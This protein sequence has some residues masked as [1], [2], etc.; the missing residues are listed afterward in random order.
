[1]KMFRKKN[2]LTGFPRLTVTLALGL[3]ICITSLSACVG[4]KSPKQS[5]GEVVTIT[6]GCFSHKVEAYNTLVAEFEQAHPNI[7]VQLVEINEAFESADPSDMIS[8][9]HALAEAADTFVWFNLELDQAARLG[10]LLNLK[11]FM[12]EAGFGADFVPGLL[13]GL[14]WADGLWVLPAYFDLPLLYYRRDP[15]GAAGVPYPDTDW[16]WDDLLSAAR[17]LT[18]HQGGETARYGFADLTGNIFVALVYQRGGELSRPE[19]GLFQPTLDSPEAVDALAWY[20]V[21]ASEYHVMP[22]PGTFDVNQLRAMADGGQIAMWTDYAS[23]LGTGSRQDTSS[24]IGVAPLPK[25]VST[26]HPIL[27]QGYAVSAGTRHP[28]AAWQW[29]EFLSR[30]TTPLRSGTPVPARN[31][32]IEAED[33]WEIVGDEAAQ[34]IRHALNHTLPSTEAWQFQTFVRDLAPVFEGEIAPEDFMTHAQAQALAWQSQ[35]AA[36]KPRPFTV[37]TPVPVAPKEAIV[38]GVTDGFHQGIYQQMAQEFMRQ[39]PDIAI[40]VQNIASG[41]EWV[42]AA[43]MRENADVFLLEVLAP[44]TLDLKPFIE[45]DE[46]FS[47]D[48]VLPEAMSTVRHGGQILGLPLTAD[49]RVIFFNKDLFDQAG[50]PYPLPDWTWDEFLEKAVLL[51]QG[52]GQDRQYGFLSYSPPQDLQL[53]VEG[54]CQIIADIWTR[55]P[56]YYFDS[57]AVKDALRWWVA[58]YREHGVMPPPRF[59]PSGDF[60]Y[61]LLSK[62]R[63]AMWTNWVSQY[64]A[65]WLYGPGDEPRLG[66]VPF[67]RGPCSVAD[68]RFQFGYISPSTEKTQECWTWLKY[69]NQRLPAGHLAPVR[70]SLLTS[71]AFRQQVGEAMADACL[72]ALQADAYL[73]SGRLGAPWINEAMDAIAEG[74]GVDEALDEAQRRAEAW[75]QEQRP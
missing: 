2:R 74:A 3:V 21:L 61:G 39:H 53:Y 49:V 47:L 56:V 10:I 43:I 25:D 33:Y 55:P 69:L 41:R 23:M 16:R 6:F 72:H 62:R 58:L 45:A 67:P 28:Q 20:V 7:N 11:P 48:D 36:E 44:R 51:T 30:R 59:G 60:S 38:F 63:V 57:P 9:L 71:D 15:F 4:E 50:V 26:A 29:I 34:A 68:V 24:R 64:G 52:E 37:A 18:V 32:L 73:N 31:A 42:D 70:Q 22:E 35:R 75:L 5:D 65:R 40:E 1:M 27:I 19:E 46:S 13:E 66:V 17:T 54:Q 12:Q 14:R 8:L